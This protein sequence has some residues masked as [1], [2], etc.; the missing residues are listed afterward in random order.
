M[1]RVE[2]IIYI[3]P[4]KRE[5]YLEKWLNP[6]KETQQI[7][8]MHGMRNQYFFQLN[9]YIL[10]T[11]E[12]VGTQFKQDMQSIAA[13]PEIDKLLVKRRRKDVAQEERTT[14]NWWAPL[15][16]AGSILT[17]SPMPEDARE[18]LSLTEQYHE[19]ISGSMREDTSPNDIAYSDDD[20]S[21]SIHI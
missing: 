20:W 11:F 15:K 9:E 17:E 10:M 19:M 18:E 14:V 1:R 3:V 2:E 8:W 5:E 21:E 16:I 7:L 13:Y 12:Y 6:S 4:E